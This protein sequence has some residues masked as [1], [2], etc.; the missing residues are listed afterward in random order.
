MDRIVSSDL[1]RCR[2]TSELLARDRE[3]VLAPELRELHFGHWEGRTAAECYLRDPVRYAQWLHDPWRVAPPGGERL[4]ELAA[5]VRAFL[6]RLAAACPGRTVAV[7]TH[8]GPIR[9]VAAPHP[10][11]IWT[12]D[13]P[14]A[15]LLVRWWRLREGVP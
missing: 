12:V 2:E 3:V 1:L 9:V 8:A 11:R 14:P 13:V 7:V 6:D 10:S 5:R 15:S 4:D